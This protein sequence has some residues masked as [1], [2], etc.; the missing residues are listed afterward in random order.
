MNKIEV[1]ERVFA[2]LIATPTVYFLMVRK[3]SIEK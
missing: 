2:T 3:A 1:F